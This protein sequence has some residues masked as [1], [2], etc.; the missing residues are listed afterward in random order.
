MTMRE[1]RAALL[2]LVAKQSGGDL[3]R[4]TLAFAA[5]RRPR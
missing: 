4:E 3:V 1:G 2:R 5:S